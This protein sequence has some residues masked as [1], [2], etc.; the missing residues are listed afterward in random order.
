MLR[1]VIK[2]AIVLGG[3]VLILMLIDGLGW[4]SPWLSE[5][6]MPAAAA[7]LYCIG[8][9]TS[10]ALGIDSS[11]ALCLTLTRLT[12]APA[13]QAPLLLAASAGLLNLIV[14]I[15]LG[16]KTRQLL[17]RDA[18][19][20]VGSSSKAVIVREGRPLPETRQRAAVRSLFRQ[21]ASRS[22]GPTRRAPD[23]EQG[24]SRSESQER[25]WRL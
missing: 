20:I 17:V 23:L 25:S 6:A 19:I 18:D 22:P 5:I 4:L 10:F 16:R 7:Y 21:A 11:T 24:L 8:L 9:P 12:G 2:A 3:P 14:L 13:E 1:A 15:Y